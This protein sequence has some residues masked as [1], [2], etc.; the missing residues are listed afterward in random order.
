MTRVG[1]LQQR[2]L[3]GCSD[4]DIWLVPLPAPVPLVPASL[5][6]CP[7]LD[8]SLPLSPDPPRPNPASLLRGRSHRQVRFVSEVPVVDMVIAEPSKDPPPWQC[9]G[10]SSSYSKG[11]RLH[12]GELR[13]R[14]RSEPNEE[15]PCEE[16]GGSLPERAELNTTL[17]LRAEL[18]NVAGAEFNSQK[19]VQEQ[20]QKSD[21]TKN[22][23]SARATEGLNVPPSQ[24]LYRALVNVNVNVE[25]EEV[26]SQALRDRLQLVSPTCSH[27]NKKED[28]PDLQVFF[29]GDLLREK[30]LLPGEEITIPRPQ[31]IPRPA[32]TTFDLYHRHTCWEAGP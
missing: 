6:R 23:I 3:A 25:E 31:P 27:G 12:G 26:I 24:H 14:A 20:L 17:A 15:A 32:D 30:P 9:P 29:R 22:S 8:L 1:P 28:S 18:D 11:K 7:E 2:P 19:A 10:H 13:W 5:L 16:R 21:R 4:P